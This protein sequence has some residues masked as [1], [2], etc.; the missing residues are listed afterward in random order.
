M[1]N[2]AWCHLKKK[3]IF[4]RHILLNLDGPRPC[5]ESFLC[6]S[7]PRRHW[8]KHTDTHWQ[9]VVMDLEEIWRQCQRVTFHCTQKLRTVCV[10]V[11]VLFLKQNYRKM[12]LFL[13]NNT[14]MHASWLGN[15]PVYK[16]VP[17]KSDCRVYFF[18]QV[19]TNEWTFH[20]YQPTLAYRFSSSK[21]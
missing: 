20:Y 11:W 13:D 18:F 16:L 19:A 2:S 15:Q 3:I 7:H 12:C 9:T 21:R 5:E 6:E 17:G 14:V 10:C 8:R 1:N 4:G